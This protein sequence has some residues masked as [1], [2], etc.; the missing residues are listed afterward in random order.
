MQYIIKI[1]YNLLKYG[2]LKDELHKL[3]IRFSSGV[4]RSVQKIKDV[5][6]LL[7]VEL[8]RETNN[9]TPDERQIQVSSNIIFII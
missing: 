9:K 2:L 3:L 8:V 5:S 4:K 1:T 7:S 6:H